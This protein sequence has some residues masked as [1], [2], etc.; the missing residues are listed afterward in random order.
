VVTTLASRFGQLRALPADWR[1]GRIADHAIIKTGSRNTQDRIDDGKY[2]FF[3]RSQIIERINDFSFNGEAVLTAG[4]GVGTGK[5]FHY[6]NGPFDCHQRVYRITDFSSELDGYYFYLYFSSHFYDRIMSMTAKSS[7]DSVRMEM[8]ADMQIPLPPLPEQRAIAQALSDVDDLIQSLERLI[9]KKRDLKQAA[10]RQLLMGKTRLTEPKRSVSFVATPF[11]YLPSDWPLLSFSE[12]C[13]R[14]QDG[15]HFSPKV[16]SGEFL[17]VTSRNVRHGFLDLS[18]AG[19]IDAKQHEAIYRRCDVRQGDVLLTKDGANTGNVAINT[20]P[21]PFSMLSSVA[22]LRFISQL[23]DPRFAVQFL[24]SRVGQRQIKDAMAGNAITRLT[25]EKIRSLRL[26]VPEFTEQKAIAEVLSD[27][28]AEIDALEARLTKT[29]ELKQG[30]MQ[31]LLT[32]R[33]RLA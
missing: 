10:M 19:R 7:V 14:I 3:V 18:T 33:T 4:D 32:G 26:P 6:I 31:E 16:G 22:F 21:S 15:T 23:I 12:L 11:G 13:Q 25:L 29:R 17:Y 30:M 1:T 8:I 20:H 2:P 24:L 27:M 9:A 28:D 5:V